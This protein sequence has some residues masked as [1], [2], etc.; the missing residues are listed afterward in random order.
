MISNENI[1]IEILKSCIEE[2][3]YHVRKLKSNTNSTKVCNLLYCV[4]IYFFETLIL[5]RNRCC[6]QGIIELE[7]TI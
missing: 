3:I 7:R 5:G 4:K 6:C 2:K 1:D